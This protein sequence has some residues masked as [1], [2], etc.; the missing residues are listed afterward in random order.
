MRGEVCIGL[1][2]LFSFTATLLLIF[3]H[4]G[5]TNHNAVGRSISL[6]SLN[7][8]GFGTAY[9]TATGDSSP[10]LYNNTP[11][12]PLGQGFGL[13]QIYNWG[14]Y[15]ECHGGW[16]GTTGICT[17]EGNGTF[18]YAFA[19]LAVLLN[20]TPPKYQTISQLLIPPSSFKNDQYNRATSKAGFYL[21]FI[22]S[23]A[24]ALAFVTG[25]IRHNVTFFAAMALSIFGA[26]M[27]LIGASV[28]TALIKRSQSINSYQV[29]TV[30]LGI[31]VSYGIALWLIWAAFITML[32]SIMPY[33]LR[34]VP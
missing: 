34:W 23:L 22:G 17:A 10:G 13:R 30:P 9:Q 31:K 2:S 33:F 12:A 24:T 16:R 4:V 5:S 18:G 7:V 15:G 3:A 27:T 20:D 1:A 14:F 6:V 32:L 25:L 8:S 21:I 29:Y 28:W 11:F 19:P 26:L